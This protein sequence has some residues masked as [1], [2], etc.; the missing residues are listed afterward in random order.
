M[1]EQKY[2]AIILV[3]RKVEIVGATSIK[4]AAM[5]AHDM[6]ANMASVQIADESVK[7]KLLRVDCEPVLL[8]EAA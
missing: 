3:P 2:F 8:P 1:D 6:L 7:P 5:V 4:M